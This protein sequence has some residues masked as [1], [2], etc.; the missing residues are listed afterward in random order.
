MIS[1]EKINNAF[2]MVF[3]LSNIYNPS[4][5]SKRKR[6]IAC[7]VYPPSHTSKEGGT[8]C[9]TLCLSYGGPSWHTKPSWIIGLHRITRRMKARAHQLLP[10]R[11]FELHCP[12][13]EASTTW[14]L[15][16]SP[17]LLKYISWQNQASMQ[18]CY[19]VYTKFCM[20]GNF[21]GRKYSKT[22]HTWIILQTLQKNC[23]NMAFNSH[24][25]KLG[26]CHSGQDS[27][28]AS[29]LKGRQAR[30]EGLVSGNL[31]V[32]TIFIFCQIYFMASHDQMKH[33]CT[34]VVSFY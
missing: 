26:Q 22:G 8:W 27:T 5:I 28:I 16:N 32:H 31:H 14:N 15:W 6:N 24:P 30:P 34:M 4:A 13:C 10:S 23:S 18:K 19:S 21:F 25:K 17:K 2:T 11:T 29:A 1:H 3:N 7:M 12:L 20:Y 33:A 9:I